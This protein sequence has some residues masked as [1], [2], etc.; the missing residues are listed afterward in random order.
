MS[1]VK[2]GR[3][4]WLIWSCLWAAFWLVMGFFTV[5]LGWIAMPLTMALGYVPLLGASDCGQV[6]GMQT[7]RRRPPYRW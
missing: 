4:I 6:I 1:T 3:M 5:G 2:T 7:D